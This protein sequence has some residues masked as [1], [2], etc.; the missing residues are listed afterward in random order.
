M[1]AKALVKTR[2]IADECFYIVQNPL[3]LC[4]RGFCTTGGEEGIRTLVGLPPN[5]FQD[6]LVMTTSILLQN[7]LQH[8][9][10]INTYILY[11]TLRQ[12]SSTVT[13]KIYFEKIP[14]QTDD[15]IL[16]TTIPQALGDHGQLFQTV[17]QSASGYL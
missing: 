17:I 6:R 9:H 11:H 13:E 4:A 14:H 7:I 12:M 8:T 16:L 5:G 15:F 1:Q 2:S 3:A 10:I